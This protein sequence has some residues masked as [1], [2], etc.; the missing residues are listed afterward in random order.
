MGAVKVEVYNELLMNS[1]DYGNVKHLRI[2]L[3]RIDALYDLFKQGDSV[4]GAIYIDLMTELGKYGRDKTSLTDREIAV[5][6]YNVCEGVPQEEVAEM[7]GIGQPM[8]SITVNRALKK[9]KQ[10]LQGE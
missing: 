3:Q 10:D 5:I 1:F 4:A 2:L 6:R 7:V 9:I 8:V